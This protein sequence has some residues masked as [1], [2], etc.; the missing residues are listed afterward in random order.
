MNLYLN[1]C[2]KYDV[3]GV[4]TSIWNAQVVDSLDSMYVIKNNGW[5]YEIEPGKSITYGYTVLG[6][7]DISLE[8]FELVS[9]QS[10]I[11]EGYEVQFEIL[12]KWSDGFKGEIEI[13]NNLDRPIE[14]WTLEFES[15]FVIKDYWGCRLEQNNEKKNGNLTPQISLGNTNTNSSL[16]MI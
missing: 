6:D 15:D 14:S 11:Q 7:E 12:D 1:W 8:S 9:I 16:S 3:N 4:I 2:F 13:V 5:N 10:V